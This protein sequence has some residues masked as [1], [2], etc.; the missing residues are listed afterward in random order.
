MFQ[1][2]NGAEVIPQ[3]IIYNNLQSNPT[4]SPEWN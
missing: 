2:N 3:E 1:K 4:D